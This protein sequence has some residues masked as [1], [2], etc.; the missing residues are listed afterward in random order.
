MDFY[1]F[2]YFY[3]CGSELH[4]HCIRPD[5]EIF[6]FLFFIFFRYPHQCWSYSRACTDGARV[7]AGRPHV[8]V[9]ATIYP[10]DNFKMDATV[11]LSHR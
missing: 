7:H 11:R 4:P 3:L 1:L 9:D 6:Y 2:I 8:R 10:Q 5:M